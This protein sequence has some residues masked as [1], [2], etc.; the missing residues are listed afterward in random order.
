MPENKLFGSFQRVLQNIA[1]TA[2][3]ATSLRVLLHRWRGVKIGKN[4]W[5]GYDVILET[6]Y[7]WLISI[8][9]GAIISIRATVIGH[10]R[11]LRGVEIGEDVLIGPGAIVMPGVKIGRGAVV[12]AG[13]VVTSSVPEMTVVQGNPAKPVARNTVPLV[14]NHTTVKQFTR[15]LKPFR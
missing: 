1:R 6:A 2:P 15:G 8:G 4:V 14:G 10:F 5:V 3:G 9:D 12:T 13:S 11:E 7:P